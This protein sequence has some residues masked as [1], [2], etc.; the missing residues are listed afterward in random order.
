MKRFIK[1]FCI[2]S[3]CLC[4]AGC[5]KEASKGDLMYEK[6]QPLIDALENGDKEKVK[7]ELNVFFGENI[8]EE[9][10]SPIEKQKDEVTSEFIE[11]TEKIAEPT[12]EFLEMEQE[13]DVILTSRKYEQNIMS[14]MPFGMLMYLRLTSGG[15]LECLYEGLG[16]RML[17]TGCLCA[18]ILV[19][20][21]G[22]KLVKIDI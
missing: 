14:L 21:L 19:W 18:Y 5:G 17:M 11:D 10:S 16:G 13:I 9:E 1:V 8:Y 20:R 4:L 6:Y 2:V 22:K 12:S 3:L 7:N 15:F